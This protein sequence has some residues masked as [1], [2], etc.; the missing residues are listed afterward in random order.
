MQGSAQEKKNVFQP[1]KRSSL[2]KNCR[3]RHR[4]R[5]RGRKNITIQTYGTEDVRHITWY[6]APLSGVRWLASRG[7][8]KRTWPMSSRLRRCISTLGQCQF[9]F[10]IYDPQAFRDVRGSFVS[11]RDV[12]RVRLCALRLAASLPQ[13][14]LLLDPLR[15]ITRTC[16]FV[17]YCS[18]CVGTCVRC[19]GT[20]SLPFYILSL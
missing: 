2:K 6:K 13:I 9:P 8:R 17:P 1:E 11:Y 18:W 5:L 12:S 20:K 16:A 10:L 4:T 3:L 15:L 14:L 7:R 19:A